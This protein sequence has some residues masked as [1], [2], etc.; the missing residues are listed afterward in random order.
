MLLQLDHESVNCDVRPVSLESRLDRSRISIMTSSGPSLFTV[1]LLTVTDTDCRLV[2][3]I[4]QKRVV[5]ILLVLHEIFSFTRCVTRF[6]GF[7]GLRTLARSSGRFRSLRLNI[8]LT[9]KQWL[10]N[11]DVLYSFF[12]FFCKWCCYAHIM[13]KGKEKAREELFLYV[14][15]WSGVLLL[16]FFF[17]L[18]NPT[19]LLVFRDISAN[20]A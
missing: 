4:Y 3:E 11:T 14:E 13:R 16:L 2:T 17:L 6:H 20:L 12:F 15:V 9:G 1:P 10:L 19:G 5:S 8:S 18:G 7:V